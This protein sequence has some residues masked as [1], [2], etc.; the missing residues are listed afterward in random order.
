MFFNFEKKPE[1]RLRIGLFL[2]DK[3]ETKKELQ[4][5]SFG[6][7]FETPEG[8]GTHNFYH[9]QPIR[10]FKKGQLELLNC[11]AW[12]P[13]AEPTLPLCA[14]NPVELSIC[15]LVS[16]YGWRFYKRLVGDGFTIEN[17]NL[18]TAEPHPTEVNRK[19]S[20]KGSRFR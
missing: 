11:P 1:I 19:P 17:W 3:L 8:E 12:L 5:K 14:T 20:R 7:R 4:I 6:F 16:L 13:T 10:H 15:L 9:A 18:E 2:L